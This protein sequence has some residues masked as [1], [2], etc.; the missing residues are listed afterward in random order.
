MPIDFIVFDEDSIKF[1]ECKTGQSPLSPKQKK[2]KQQI[3]NGL[4][5]FKEVRYG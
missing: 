5:E 3:E 1:I 4:V 2:I